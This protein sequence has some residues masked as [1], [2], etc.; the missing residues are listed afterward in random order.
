VLKRFALVL[1]QGEVAARN[2]LKLVKKRMREE[3]LADPLMCTSDDDVR[4]EESDGALEQYAPGPPA[5]KVSLG[6]VSRVEV[7]GV[8]RVDTAGR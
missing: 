7:S 6:I 8:S 2:I 1:L 3:R 4:T 5:I